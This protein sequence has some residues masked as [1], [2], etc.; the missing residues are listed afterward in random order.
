[1]VAVDGSTRAERAWPRTTPS[2]AAS[3]ARGAAAG[4]T[5]ERRG[6]DRRAPHVL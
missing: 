1:L 4:T 2:P 3:R 6:G 5:I